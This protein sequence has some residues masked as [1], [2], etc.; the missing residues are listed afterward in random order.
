MILRFFEYFTPRNTFSK[1]NL[2]GSDWMNCFL[3]KSPVYTYEFFWCHRDCLQ[4]S[5][6]CACYRIYANLF[7]HPQLVICG[8]RVWFV[9]TLFLN[10]PYHF[11]RSSKHKFC[12]SY[13]EYCMLPHHSFSRKIKI[14]TFHISV[15]WYP[16]ISSPLHI[17]KLNHME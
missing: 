5:I 10:L 7:D 16:L 9:L 14:S 8:V 17:N 11:I 2:R 4:L 13:K 3:Y 15:W 6:F 12:G 1:E